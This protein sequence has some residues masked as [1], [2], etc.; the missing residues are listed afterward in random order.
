MDYKGERVGGM[1]KLVCPWVSGENLQGQAPVPA[2]KGR[3]GKGFRSK[4]G[5]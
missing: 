1:D 3:K 4:R 5:D 2:L